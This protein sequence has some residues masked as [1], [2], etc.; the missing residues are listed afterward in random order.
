MR[1]WLDNKIFT[2]ILLLLC[3]LFYLSSCAP[4]PRRVVQPPKTDYVT[5][6]WY[7][8]KF[9]GRL[10]ASGE[11]F[12]MYA[13][14]CAHREFPFGTRLRVTNLGNKK[15]VVVTVNDRGPFI[16]GRELDLSYAAAEKI[17][18]IGPGVAQVRI[19]SLGRDM[20]YV[21]S[22]KYIPSL[23]LG[24]FTVQVGA[25][26]EKTN[27]ERL[28][29]GL[30]L[31]YGDVYIIIT[32]LNRQKFYRVRIGTFDNIDHAY[33]FA[34]ILAEEGYGIFITKKH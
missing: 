10:T 34:K 18:L 2:K 19:E 12:D 14:T 15:S 16:H 31:K 3:T 4:V 30:Q 29:Q 17:G 13:M 21:K 7:G 1:K 23:S 22:I 25:F 26:R 33:S 9:H 6:S 5:A 32:Y 24:S 27:A 28:K 8:P 11:K 20:R